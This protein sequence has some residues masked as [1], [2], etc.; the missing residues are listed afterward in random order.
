V[1]DILTKAL[2]QR[3]Q[4]EVLADEKTLSR[5]ATDMSMYRIQPLAV[6]LPE[7]A[8]DVVATIRFAAQEGIPVTCRGGGSST[9]GSA[10]GRGI[11]LSFQRRG[12]MSRILDFSEVDGEPRVRVEPALV[13]DDLQTFLR[14]RG[15]YL[16]SDPSSGAISVLG[17][18]VATKASGPHA[19]RHGS[20]DRYLRHLQFITARGELVDAFA[21]ASWPCAMICW[22]ISRR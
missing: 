14:E 13:H 7:N 20:I 4:G 1:S 2:R 3:V 15:L 10:L 8:H 9:A 19:L 21:M 11:I 17:G 5:H 16:P 12:P 6:V 18:N 22:P